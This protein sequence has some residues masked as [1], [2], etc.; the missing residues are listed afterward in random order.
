MTATVIIV[1]VVNTAAAET[2]TAATATAKCKNANAAKPT[3]YCY[4]LKTRS[5]SSPDR[6]HQFKQLVMTCWSDRDCHS[7]LES[8]QEGL[9]FKRS[10]GDLMYGDGDEVTRRQKH[11]KSLRMSV[12]KL[13]DYQVANLF[14]TNG[15]NG[16]CLEL[17]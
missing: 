1:A 2:T 8:C 4:S 9:C 5:N 7:E 14:G 3:F 13:E 11:V 15:M 6:R 12:Q 16:F 17:P 10:I